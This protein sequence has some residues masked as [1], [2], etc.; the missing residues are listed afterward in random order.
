MMSGWEHVYLGIW[1]T[2][3]S[4]VEFPLGLLSK[5]CSIRKQADFHGHSTRQGCSISLSTYLM[6]YSKPLPD[7][8]DNKSRQKVS[9]L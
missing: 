7:Q 4:L 2:V 9:K 1:L 8:L 5:S 6:K 3:L